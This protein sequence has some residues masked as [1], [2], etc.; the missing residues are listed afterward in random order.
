MCHPSQDIYALGTV[1]MEIET[2]RVGASLQDMRDF[3]AS[4]ENPGDTAVVHYWDNAIVDRLPL[5][6]EKLQHE[7]NTPSGL[8]S[9]MTQMMK[10]AATDRPNSGEV[11]ARLNQITEMGDHMCCDW[12]T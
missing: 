4:R 1:F 2:V 7:K 11:L 8:A 5:W 10:M 12:C 3:L 9:L 6:I